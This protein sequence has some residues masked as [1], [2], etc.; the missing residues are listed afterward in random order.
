MVLAT[1]NFLCAQSETTRRRMFKLAIILTYIE[2]CQDKNKKR[3]N[4]FL[5]INVQVGKWDRLCDL[6]TWIIS[7]ATSLTGEISSDSIKDYCML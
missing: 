4:I 5:I 2:M 6:V 7:G 3:N 1:M